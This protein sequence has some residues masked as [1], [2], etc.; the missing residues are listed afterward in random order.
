[1]PFPDWIGSVVTWRGLSVESAEQQA[2]AKSQAVQAGLAESYRAGVCCLGE[3]ASMPWTDSQY[4][5]HP[6]ALTLFHEFLGLTQPRRAWAWAQIPTALQS[7]SNPADQ[8]LSLHQATVALSPHAP[9]TVRLAD[10]ARLAE[11]GPPG[12][13][14]DRDASRGISRRDRDAHGKNRSVRGF[15]PVD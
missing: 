14:A 12:G 6:L 9:Y 10:V 8:G 1:M 15:S 5:N 11:R 4:R 3:I 2:E 7:T 13:P